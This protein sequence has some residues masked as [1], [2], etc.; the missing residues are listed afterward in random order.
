M[1]TEITTSLSHSRHTKTA[2]A[3]QAP[4]VDVAVASPRYPLWC[5]IITAP[6]MESSFARIG[7]ARLVRIT[8]AAAPMMSPAVSLS[9]EK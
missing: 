4:A 2:G 3:A 7:S 6:A 8:G 5:A 1:G 9:L